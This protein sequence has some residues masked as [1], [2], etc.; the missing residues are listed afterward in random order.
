VL[1]VVDESGRPISGEIAVSENET[2]WQFTPEERWRAG[3][4]RLV[5]DSALEDLAGNSIRRP[6]EV[7]MARPVE[8]EEVIE[9]VSVPFRVTREGKP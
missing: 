1:H 3:D 8:S 2:R 4:Y 9:T 6:F 5:I 7:D